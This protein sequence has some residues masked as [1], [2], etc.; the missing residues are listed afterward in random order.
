MSDESKIKKDCILSYNHKNG[1]ETLKT[2]NFRNI[3]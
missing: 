2:W 1:H 3:N